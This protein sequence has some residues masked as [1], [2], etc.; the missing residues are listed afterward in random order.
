MS[1]PETGAR[2][3]SCLARI[4]QARKGPSEMAQ[5]IAEVILRDPAAIVGLS[6]TELAGRCSVSE[7][8]I[9]RF[10]RGLGYRGYRQ[11]ALA[12]ASATA[13]PQ[14]QALALEL[15]ESDEPA[16]VLEKVFAAEAKALSIAWQTVDPH[17]WLRAVEALA[18]ARRVHCYAVGGSGLLAMEACY[19]LIRLDIDCY[20]VCDPIQIAIQAARLTG[21]DVA[22]GFSQ[23][24][25][26]R[27]TVE[28]LSAARAAG[29]TTICVTSQPGSPITA[30]S[31]IALVLLELHTAYRGAYL[32][33][34]IAELTLID[35]LCACVARQGEPPSLHADERISA[36]IERMMAGPREARPHR[37][38]P[39]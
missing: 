31:D 34:K 25:R 37:A 16:T 8:S 36:S 22:I 20:A 9:L 10:A 13:E 6:I 5:Q 18:R 27:D 14:A 30:A 19:R 38:R 24:G 17:S 26:T 33:S 2:D 4:G 35:A 21:H 11:F 39:G 7:T 15:G 29:A 23:T 28:G 12:L 32:D 3:L 1:T